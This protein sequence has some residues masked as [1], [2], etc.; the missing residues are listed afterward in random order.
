MSDVQERMFNITSHQG[1]AIN[2]TMRY[3]LTSITLATTEKK[4]EIS[5]DEEKEN[6]ASLC[7]GDENV[8]WCNCYGKHGS[9]SK[10]KKNIITI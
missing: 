5:F 1:K 9:F 6:L 4:Q 2:I 10:I 7:T 3:H 8:K